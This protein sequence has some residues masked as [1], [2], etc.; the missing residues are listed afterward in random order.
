MAMMRWDP[1][2]EFL[3]LSREMDRVLTGMPTA[4]HAGPTSARSLVAPRMDIFKRGDD[5]VIRAEM[6]G[7]AADDIDISVEEGMLTI[8]A[9]RS[10]EREVKEED[11]LVREVSRGSIRRS[12]P[13]PEGVDPAALK[14]DYND[15]VLEIVAPQAALPETRS[16]KVPVG[17]EQRE[18]ESKETEAREEA[19]AETPG[20][21]QGASGGEQPQAQAHH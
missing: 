11:Y 9:E 18:L 4:R 20:M 16:Y 5:L 12:M 2:G 14:A 15:G 13:L 21:Q 17:T 1:F 6:P 19:S 10:S 3:G 8:S 7:M